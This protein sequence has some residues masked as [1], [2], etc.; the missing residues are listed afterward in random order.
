[1]SNIP[2]AAKVLIDFKPQHSFF[3]GI[4]SDG[5]AFDAME[6]K[7]KECFAPSTIKALGLQSVSKYARETAEFVNLYSTTRG[8]NRRGKSEFKGISPV[9]AFCGFP[10]T[11]I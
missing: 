1:M 4:D 3:V 9:D 6:I 7:H 2:E 11:R 10:D 5:C 8:L